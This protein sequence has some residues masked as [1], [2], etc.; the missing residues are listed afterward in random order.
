MS[1][2]AI[3]SHTIFEARTVADTRSRRSSVTGTIA[4]L[5]SIVVNG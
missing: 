4:M 1:W 2:K 5:G 3:V